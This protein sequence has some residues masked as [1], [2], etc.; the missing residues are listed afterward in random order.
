MIRKIVAFSLQ[1]RILVVFFVVI[2]AVGGSVAFKN[3]PIEAYPDI[4]DTWVQVI[5]QWPG[6]AAEEIERQITVP[7]E[8]A[9][10]GVPHQTHIRSVSLFGLS[11]VTLIFDEETKPFTARQY[12]LE[13]LSEVILPQGVQPSLGPMSSPVGQIYWYILDS[14]RSPMELKEIEDWDLEKRLK[15]IPGVA[16]VVS[17]GGMVK[18]YQALVNPLALANYGLS[19]ANIVQ[20]LSS[21]NQNSGGGSIPRIGMGY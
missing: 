15:E 20:A 11:V 21:N 19:T 3:L 4:A 5:N 13:K 7:I 12:T 17:F 2:I 16:D 10:N 9:M 14:K 8:I 1:K 18:Q 6:H